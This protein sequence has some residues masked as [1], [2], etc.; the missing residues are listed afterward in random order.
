MKREIDTLERIKDE[1]SKMFRRNNI[2]F[3]FGILIRIKEL[4]VDIS[5]RCMELA[6]KVLKII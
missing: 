3:D 5:S 6:L 1:E 4:M 2:E